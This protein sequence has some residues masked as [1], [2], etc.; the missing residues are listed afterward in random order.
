MNGTLY[1]SLVLYSAQCSNAG[2]C[3]TEPSVPYRR[4]AARH[5]VHIQLPAGTDNATIHVSAADTM[6]RLPALLS[7][8]SA[9][10]IAVAQLAILVLV[11]AV[12]FVR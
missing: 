10:L 7:S 1:K 8:E 5:T 6:S 12:S 2:S 9:T 4:L 3:Q 11:A